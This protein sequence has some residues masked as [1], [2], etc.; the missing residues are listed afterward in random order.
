MQIFSNILLGGGKISRRTGL[1][2]LVTAFLALGMN[3]WAP[4]AAMYDT[5]LTS[6]E[7]DLNGGSSFTA[8]P[9]AGNRFYVTNTGSSPQTATIS[10]NLDVVAG[11]ELYLGF[12]QTAIA[13]GKVRVDVSGNMNIQGGVWVGTWDNTGMY[14]MLFPLPTSPSKDVELNIAGDL[15]VN[16]VNQ[17]YNALM[18]GAY[19]SSSSTMITVSGNTNLYSGGNHITGY[20]DSTLHLATATFNLVGGEIEVIGTS[21]TNTRPSMP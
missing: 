2:A 1:G 13:T 11:S 5:T 12:T 8:G 9:A 7:F 18:V 4:A 19:G 10:G 20:A 17:G 6:A 16:V 21:S 3:G 14:G 15:N